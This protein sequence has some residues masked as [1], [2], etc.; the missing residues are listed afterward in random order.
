MKPGWSVSTM[1]AVTPR[2]FFSG[3]V[4]VKRMMYVGIGRGGDP[5]LTAV[6]HVRPCPAGFSTARLF[7]VPASLPLIGSVRL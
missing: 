3:W 6:D 7:I 1:K 4:M 2:C 5:R